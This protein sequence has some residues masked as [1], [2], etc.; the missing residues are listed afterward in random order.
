MALLSDDELNKLVA[1]AE[2]QPEQ[3]AGAASWPIAAL[4][5]VMNLAWMPMSAGLNAFPA[6]PIKSYLEGKSWPEIATSPLT[7]VG[8]SIS[9]GFGSGQ[10]PSWSDFA[11]YLP[12]GRTHPPFEGER[13]VTNPELINLQRLA[14]GKPIKTW[15]DVQKTQR[16]AGI[17]I[18]TPTT[19]RDLIAKALSLAEGGAAFF[20]NPLRPIASAIKGKPIKPGQF[21]NNPLSR[22]ARRQEPMPLKP[23]QISAFESQRPP[24]T[25]IAGEFSNL[26]D[27]PPPYEEPPVQLGNVEDILQQK[28]LA[29]QQRYRQRI[30]RKEAINKAATSWFEEYPVQP[31]PEPPTPAP[32][33]WK[34]QATGER[35]RVQLKGETDF[36]PEQTRQVVAGLYAAKRRGAKFDAAFFDELSNRYGIDPAAM[37]SIYEQYIK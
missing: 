17:P 29:R 33:T 20:V 11:K 34:P 30:G 31:T 8:Q 3:S 24:A 35:G 26:K 36:T 4:E 7:T 18:S 6:A 23:E 10:H 9:A 14:G 37:N 28:W 12:E 27:K 15:E 25:T 32:E 1:R 5:R 19:D 21:F 13:G 22:A 2:G 16:E